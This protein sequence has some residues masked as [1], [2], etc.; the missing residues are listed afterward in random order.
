MDN[1]EYLTT[2]EFVKY[3]WDKFKEYVAWYVSRNPGSSTPG[4]IPESDIATDD[5]VSEMLDDVFSSV[6]E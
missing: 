3:I 2:Q 4:E 6:S 5:E 1:E